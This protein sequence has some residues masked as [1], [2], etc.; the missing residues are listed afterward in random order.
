VV[1]VGKVGAPMRGAAWWSS[2]WM[3][4]RHGARG[5]GEARGG[6]VGPGWRPEATGGVEVFTAESGRRWLRA[7]ERRGLR[8]AQVDGWSLADGDQ[9]CGKEEATLRQSVT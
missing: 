5:R 9:G 8:M 4:G 1:R 6:D 7:R 3:V 2:A